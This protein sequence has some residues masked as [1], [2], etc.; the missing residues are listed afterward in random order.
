[1]K[2]KISLKVVPLTIFLV[3]VL[4]LDNGTVFMKAMKLLF[5]GV[6]VCLIIKRGYINWNRYLTWLLLFTLLC[7]LSYFW[8]QS[9][10]YAIS[11]MMTVSLNSL[12]LLGMSQFMDN[13]QKSVNI[14]YE[15]I[16]IAPII[17]FAL[18]MCSYG[19]SVF[20]GLR[21]IGADHN[22]TGMVAGLGVTFAFILLNKNR[23]D[24]KYLFIAA[25]NVFIV[26][27]TMSRK[28]LLYL[29]L[30][31]LIYYVL[32]GRQSVKRFAK[33]ISVP[34]LIGIG[35]LLIMK[36]PFLYNKVGSGIEM[37][38]SFF[39]NGYGDAS[40]AG[41]NTRIV[42]GIGW[43]NKKP[44]LGYGIM[45]YN[46]L[47]K[48]FDPLMDMVIADNN[49]IDIAVNLGIVGL[50]MYFSMHVYT[51]FKSIKNVHNNKELCFLCSILITL[52]ICD[53]GS[54]SYIYMHSQF[55][56]MLVV[57]RILAILNCSADKKI[58]LRKRMR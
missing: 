39:I 5:V 34:I 32:S 26:L 8:A 55:Y 10:E 47:F 46:Y 40:A 27:L 35:W 31:L 15:C 44:I 56:L 1:M 29:T 7:N 25:I 3:C 45:N 4:A 51:L 37:M 43:F 13:R 20:Q 22:G 19:F 50:L 14:L 58:I 54:S 24:H 42:Q 21:N 30:P 28:A 16:T 11:G 23:R 12:C 52:I 49:Y 36:I 41:R 2:I 17:K 57:L 38:M 48:Q 33:M 53:Y 18:L 9:K 6:V